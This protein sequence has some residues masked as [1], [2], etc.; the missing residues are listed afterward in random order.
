MINSEIIEEILN[1]AVFAPSGDNSQ[2]WHFK[3]KADE[4]YIF[5][6][7]DKD[8]PFYNYKQCGSFVAHGALLENIV[9]LA[10]RYGLDT[11]INL[12]PQGPQNEMVAIIRFEV[13]QVGDSN[14]L[15]DLINKRVTN[16]RPYNVT[17]ISVENKQKILNIQLPP[18]IEVKFIDD[19]DKIKKISNAS[20]VNEETV[21]TTKFI[22]NFFFKHV[23]WSESDERVKR[24][25]LFVKTLEMPKPQEIAFRLASHWPIMCIANLFGITKKIASDNA[26]L[27]QASPA[28]IAF[29]SKNDNSV[30]F[31]N[32]GRAMQRVWL[33]CT[34]E[35]IYAHPVTGVLFLYQRV[36]AKE[37]RGIN[38]N[39][40][41][42]IEKSY[43]II[44]S[45]CGA[46]GNN[47]LFLLRIGKATVPSATSSRLKPVIIIN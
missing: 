8:L 44:S 18:G 40:I 34:R 14:K 30:D 37:A 2:P 10:S 47:I 24:S 1:Q 6:I 43:K 25:G 19:V 21:L 7:P 35:G 4:L 27:F 33:I 20:V 5:N 29:L 17:P 39:K 3:I 9:I 23:V 41:E 26:K 36:K 13:A 11:D 22:H 12:F 15:A 28:F 42:K 16:R 31:I 38:E 46:E 32:I 45:E